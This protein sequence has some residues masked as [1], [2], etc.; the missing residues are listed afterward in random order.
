[1]PVQ[2]LES[3]SKTHLWQIAAKHW[4]NHPA[5]LKKSGN[6]EMEKQARGR[7]QAGNGTLHWSSAMELAPGYK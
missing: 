4:K 7:L 6:Q 1:M 5:A 2:L 3:K